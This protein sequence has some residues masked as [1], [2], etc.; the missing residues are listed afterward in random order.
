MPRKK[1]I[2][3]SLGEFVGH[4]ARGVKTRVDERGDA[5]V[6]EEV[7]RTV[8]ETTDERGV[9]LRRTTID[10]IEFPANTTAS[11]PTDEPE[12]DLADDD[13]DQAATS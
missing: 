1:S 2:A 3:R 9:T 5:V 10:E 7:K 12:P 13:R 11:N 6:R 8:E 4:I